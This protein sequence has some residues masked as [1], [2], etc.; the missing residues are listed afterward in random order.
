GEGR[1]AVCVDCLEPLEAEGA[2]DAWQLAQL[3]RRY[4]LR[5]AR[6]LC[7]QGARLADPLRLDV[8]GTVGVGRD[9]EID[10]DVIFEGEVEPG[11]GVR[12]GPFCRLKNVRLAA[13][14]QVRAHCDLE[15]AVSEGAAIIGPFARLRPGTVLADGVHIGNFVETK[16]ASLGAGS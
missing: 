5:Q 11:D 3:E 14:T 4:Q 10:V 15:G 8:R 2:N 12:I 9:V 16:A 1:G 7:L 6:A 13:G